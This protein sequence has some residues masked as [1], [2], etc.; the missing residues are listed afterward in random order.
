M[1]PNKSPRQV[2]LVVVD[3][4]QSSTVTAQSGFR[5]WYHFGF[6]VRPVGEEG[7][8]HG[9]ARVGWEGKERKGGEG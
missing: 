4:E 8:G 6:G 1:I 7:G 2:L 9:R 5:L 3:P